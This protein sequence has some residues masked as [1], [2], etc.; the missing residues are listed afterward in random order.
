M[1]TAKKLQFAAFRG[2]GGGGCGLSK[3]TTCPYNQA[4]SSAPNG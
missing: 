1:L 3:L 2:Y 4:L